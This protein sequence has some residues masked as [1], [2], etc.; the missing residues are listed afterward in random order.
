MANTDRRTIRVLAPSAPGQNLGMMVPGP[1]ETP[2]L[3][4]ARK[5]LRE[6]YRLLDECCQALATEPSQDSPAQVSMRAS[7][8]GLKLSGNSLSRCLEGARQWE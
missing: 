4:E 3:M 8:A 6:A 5:H 2:K 7:L 1:N